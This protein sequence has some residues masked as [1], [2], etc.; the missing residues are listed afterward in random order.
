MSLVSIAVIAVL[1]LVLAFLLGARVGGSP[2]A[3]PSPTASATP[4]P[5]AS[6][7][8]TPVAA[9]PVGP[10][11]A[12]EHEWDELGGGECI[13]PWVSPWETEFTVVDCSAPHPAQLVSTGLFGD[14]GAPYPGE[15]AL[16]G[17]LNLLC[18][19]P[20]A[21]DYGAASAYPDVQL[22][23]SYPASEQRWN[24]GDRRYYCFAFLGGGGALTGSL[25]PAG[26]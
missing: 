21:L 24:E 17:Q 2:A 4:S 26:R 25:A 14:E 13:D 15:Q 9:P 11:P 6:P 7:T 19:A 23:A 5:T 1:G 10:A 3:A 22:Q 8:P 18:S 20:T 12:G 16:V